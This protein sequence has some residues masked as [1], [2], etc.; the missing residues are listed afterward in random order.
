MIVKENI[1]LSCSKI[2]ID[3]LLTNSVDGPLHS[4][5]FGKNKLKGLQ[6]DNSFTLWPKTKFVGGWPMVFAMGKF[7]GEDGDIQ[8]SYSIL[9]VFPFKY[10]NLK[11]IPITLIVLTMIISWVSLVFSLILEVKSLI[12]VLIPLCAASI[13]SVICIFSY[14]YICEPEIKETE[15]ILRHLFEKY[16][17]SEPAASGDR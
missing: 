15:K 17:I 4:V 7:S 2:C 5:W 6:K 14:F 3:D 16:R 9:P 10:F 8:I 1:K 12:V 11:P 13:S